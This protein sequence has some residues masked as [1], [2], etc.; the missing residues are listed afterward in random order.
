M[1]TYDILRKKPEP[2]PPEVKEPPRTLFQI[3]AEKFKHPQ[4]QQQ[5]QQQPGANNRESD[6]YAAGAQWSKVPYSKWVEAVVKPEFPVGTLVTMA[7]VPFVPGTAPFPIYKVEGVQEIHCFVR[8]DRTASEPMAVHV[9]L[10]NGSI[11]HILSYAPCRLR[12]LNEQELAI[13]RLRDQAP[14][15]FGDRKTVVTNESDSSGTSGNERFA[16]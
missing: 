9:R 8:F 11:N 5:R 4:Q 16:G 1:L 3:V 15:G 14:Q 2:P 7:G 6:I 12:R 13:A 10:M